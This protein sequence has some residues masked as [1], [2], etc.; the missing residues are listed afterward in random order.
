MPGYPF[1]RIRIKIRGLAL[2]VAVIAVLFA[3]GVGY[4]GQTDRARKCRRMAMSHSGCV[5]YWTEYAEL[6]DQGVTYIAKNEFGENVL[7]RLCYYPLDPPTDLKGREDFDRQCARLAAICRARATYHEQMKQ[8]W[9]SAARHPW[10]S[11]GP[12]PPPPFP[13]EDTAIKYYPY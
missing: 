7:H 6:S 3:A 13:I 2:A 5:R 4:L 12:D 1:S 8:R 11:V 10:E 9:L